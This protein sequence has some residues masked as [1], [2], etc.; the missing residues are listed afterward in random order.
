MNRTIAATA[1]SLLLAATAFAQN[2]GAT[3]GSST[4]GSPRNTKSDATSLS[5]QDQK[6]VREAA[7]G[8]MMEVMLGKVAVQKASSQDVKDFGQRMVDDHSKAN[9]QLS[10]LASQKGLTLPTALPANMQKDMDKLS[11]LSGAEFDRM[12]MGHMVKDHKKDVAEFEKEA[13]KAADSSLKSFAQQ[14]LPTLREHLTMAQTIAPKVGAN[15]AAA[16]H[17]DHSG[18]H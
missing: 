8:G 13:S 16:D 2:Q 17:G 7:A 1:L 14:T 6:F 9:Q 11:A 12:Y 5:A 15:M 3:T 4:A 10:S 18:K